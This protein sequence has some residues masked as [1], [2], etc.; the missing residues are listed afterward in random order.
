MSIQGRPTVKNADMVATLGSS[1][2]RLSVGTDD[3]R[4]FSRLLRSPMHSGG[5][6]SA[7]GCCRERRRG[8]ALNG[9]TI[10]TLARWS[11]FGYG[12][13][14]PFP[15][16]PMTWRAAAATPATHGAFSPWKEPGMRRR[17]R[18]RRA[19]PVNPG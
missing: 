4:Q 14:L 11:G 17:F 10:T 16:P 8:H 3:H 5:R 19:D 9:E 7:H 13:I 15:D 12:I 6:R 18:P 2:S 1:C